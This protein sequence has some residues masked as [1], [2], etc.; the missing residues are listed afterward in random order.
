MP[1]QDI[2]HAPCRTPGWGIRGG[3][4]DNCDVVLSWVFL[5]SVVDRDGFDDEWIT[6]SV[7]FDIYGE[8]VEEFPVAL[9]KA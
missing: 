4:V 3:S 6:G 8:A 2:D 7:V 5:K 9:Q 1:V